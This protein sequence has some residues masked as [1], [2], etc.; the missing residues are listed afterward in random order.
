VVGQGVVD[1][2]SGNLPFG[3]V[4]LKLDG[5]HPFDNLCDG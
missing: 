5:V 4:N 2:V 1:K 3:G